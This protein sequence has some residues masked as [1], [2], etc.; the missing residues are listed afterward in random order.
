MKVSNKCTVKIKKVKPV[1]VLPLAL[2]QC[3]WNELGDVGFE[4]QQQTFFLF[5]RFLL[6]SVSLFHIQECFLNPVWCI[7]GNARLK[8]KLVMKDFISPHGIRVIALRAGSW[9]GY[10]VACFC[11]FMQDEVLKILFGSMRAEVRTGKEK[12]HYEGLRNL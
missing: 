4:S 8:I 2:Q 6:V 3:D 11:I 1:F 5:I 10:K 7:I 12:L 9:C